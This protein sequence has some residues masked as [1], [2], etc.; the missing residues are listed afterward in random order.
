MTAGTGKP[1]VSLRQQI[2]PLLL[3]TVFTLLTVSSMYRMSIT[4]DEV[5]H[6]PAGYTYVKTG[7]FRLNMQHPPL[8]KALAGIPLLA[9]DLKPLAGN[10]LWEQAREWMF[11]R[12]F[13]VNNDESLSRIV[14]LARLP[15]VGVALLMGAVLFLW[16]KELWGYWTGVFVLFLFTFSPNMLANAPLVHTDIGVS[17][18]TVA[19]LYALWKFSRTG[20]L[21]YVVL[22]GGGLGL[23]LLAKYS[24][25]VTAL[26]VA[27]LLA[28]TLLQRLLGRVPSDASP[29]TPSGLAGPVAVP[30]IG[31][32]VASGLVI[33]CLA[34][35]LIA[36]GFGFPNGLAN[37]YS[38]FTI[39]H[40]D[41]N[42]RWEGFLWGQYSPTGFWYYYLFAQLWKTP[43]PV[44][45]F[46]GFSLFLVGSTAKTS[47]LDWSFMLL[48]IAAF[49]AAGM[50][51]HASIGV[52]HVLP[53]FP[54]LF[55]AAG[56]TASWV[57]RQRVSL[58]LRS[59][60]SGRSWRVG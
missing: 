53:A 37:Y 10:P 13:L 55:L 18:F 27:L 59:R 42:P 14:F 19:T 9:L 39:I 40:A 5:T 3:L 43:I 6:L 32:I 57:G 25:V 17:C 20:K 46:F 36:I 60:G 21:R 8:I 50:W 16:A 26:L 41:A 31:K 48:P 47:W 22:C 4:G 1:F 54:F 28:A 49:H 29:E 15:M 33:G 45:L 11:G 56:A 30:R 23:A 52:R 58:Q 34:V 35:L 24:G 12:D 51:Q 2:L 44:L 7:D 38:G